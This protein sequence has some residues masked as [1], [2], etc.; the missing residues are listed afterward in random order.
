MTSFQIITAVFSSSLLA[1]GLTSVANYY[2]TSVNYRNEYYKKLLDRRLTAYEDVHHFLSQLR[3]LVH[4]NDENTLT[5]YLLFNGVEALE[6]TMI[7]ILVPMKSSTWVSAELSD[8]L[9]KLNVLLVQLSNEANSFENPDKELIRIGS[10]RLH[11]IRS[12]R[13]EIETLMKRDFRTM[14]DIKNFLS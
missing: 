10:K 12:Y 2:L 7:S 11:E 1:A 9:T 4:D 13:E 14:H 3:M 6:K 8:S 5:P